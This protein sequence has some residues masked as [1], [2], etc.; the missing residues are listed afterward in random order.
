[1][2]LPFFS[3]FNLYLK[4]FLMAPKYLIEIVAEKMT[5]EDLQRL[6]ITL[7]EAEYGTLSLRD[8]IRILFIVLARKVTDK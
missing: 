4:N 5:E 1:M 6:I 8:I 7:C 3:R 2:R